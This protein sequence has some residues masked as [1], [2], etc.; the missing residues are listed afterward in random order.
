MTRKFKKVK[1]AIRFIVPFLG[2]RKLLPSDVKGM[3]L[4]PRFDWASF[5]FEWMGHGV[6]LGVRPV[7]P[8]RSK[9]FS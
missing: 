4:D 7:Q 3:G 5:E 6:I 2:F 1:K 9:G 8:A